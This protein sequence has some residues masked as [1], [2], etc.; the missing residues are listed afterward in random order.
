MGDFNASVGE[1]NDEKVIGKY[2]LGERNE[3]GEMLSSFCK[4]NKFVVT[5]TWLQQEKRRR[6]T[7]KRPGEGGERFQIDYILVRQGYRN[8]VKCSRSWASA[9]AYSDHNLVAM[10]MNIKWKTLRRTKRKHKWNIEHLKKNNLPYRRDVEEAMGNTM[11]KGMDVNQRWIDFKGVVIDSAKEQIGYERKEKIKKSWVTEDISK[12]DERRN[13]KNENDEYGRQKYRQLNNELRREVAKAKEKWWSKECQELEELDSKGRADLVYAKV[14]NLTWKKKVANKSASV[15]D[16]AGNIVTEPEEVRERWRQYIESLYD[17][18]GK[19]KIE[20]IQVEEREEV[21]EEEIG[22]QVLKSE[23]LVA[24]SEMMEG[25]AVGV[26]AIPAEM[27]KCLGE[28]ATQELCDICQSMFEEGKWPDDF[29]RTAM[30]PLPKKTNAVNCSD[31]RTISLICHASK[32]MLKVLTKRIE[33]QAKHVLRRSQFGFRKGCGTRDAVGVM[34]TLC[35]RSLKYGNAVYICFVDFEKAF[36][37]VN[38]VKMF[39]IMKSLHIDWR[40]RRLLQDPYIR[41]EAV[42]RVRGEDSDPE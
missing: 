4:K 27:L 29:T 15:K 10:E 32:I 5:N 28:K 24:I 26:D 23:I 35:E 19:P 17:R 12:M 34:R 16:D 41:Q 11:R 7:W 8:S 25:K 20:D 30:L 33:A 14:A 9:D 6:Y 2:G 13:W 42:V 1:G 31:C 3:R 22:P 39:E 18:D 38:W 21:D 40:D 37:R 36:D